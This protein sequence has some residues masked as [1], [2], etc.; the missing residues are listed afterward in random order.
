MV[1][2]IYKVLPYFVIFSKETSSIDSVKKQALLILHVWIQ[3]KAGGSK[4]SVTLTRLAQCDTGEIPLRTLLSDEKPRHI[5]SDI[6]L[7]SCE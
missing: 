4:A 2:P 6:S 3:G 7:S 5:N 1:I